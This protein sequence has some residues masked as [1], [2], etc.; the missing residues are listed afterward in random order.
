MIVPAALHLGDPRPWAPETPPETFEHLRERVR[1]TRWPRVGDEPSWTEGADPDFLRE[2]ARQWSENYDG[3]AREGQVARHPW[4]EVTA[5]RGAEVVARV[6]FIHATAEPGQRRVP[7]LLCHGWPDSAWR[8]LDVIDEL[9]RPAGGARGFDVV[10]PEMP[11]FGY[12]TLDG[13]PLNSIEVA[14]LWAALMQRLGYSRYLVAG[15]DIG[16]AVS[17]Y[18]ALNQP[19]RVI[20]V[21]RMDAGIPVYTGDPDALT[22]SER[23]WLQDAADW[24]AREGAYAALH[25]TKPL[26]IGAALSDSP[27]GLAAWVVEKLRAW[28]D[29]GD[30]DIPPLSTDAMLDLITTMWLTNSATAGMRMYRAN[31]AIPLVE[32]ARRVEVPSGFSI[33][34]G[35]LL[36]PPRE[37]LNRFSHLTRLTHPARGGH[38]APREVP[39]LYVRELRAF[40]TTDDA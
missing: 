21:H 2:L 20:A 23:R 7:L 11:G 34:P 25:R 6:R 36:S 40:F 17:R 5:Y 16:S 15:G 18:L 4:Y 3:A 26:T 31:A 14:E 33:F 28:T 19:E 1:R 9:S 13:P 24:G 37:W 30:A 22:E 8:Y 10:V 39:D 12:S 29:R 38:F 35:D 27:I 32:H